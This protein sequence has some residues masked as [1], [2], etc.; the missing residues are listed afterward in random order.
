MLNLTERRV[1]TL[2]AAGHWVS[3]A[4]MLALPAAAV[5]LKSQFHLGT[6]EYGLLAN[7]S[8]LGFG[9]GALPAGFLVDGIGPRRTLYICLGGI[10]LGALVTALADGLVM[11]AV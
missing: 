4:A 11:L 1:I 10:A 6:F 7:L 5:L 2:T 3:H 9:L 8:Y